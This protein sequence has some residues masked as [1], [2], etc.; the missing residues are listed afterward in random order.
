M[1]IRTMHRRGLK[2]FG[3]QSAK[4]R[5]RKRIS[6]RQRGRFGAIPVQA[7]VVPGF[8][9]T[10]GFFG[11][12][13]RGGELKFL[14]QDIDDAA[15]A[16]GGTVFLNG[17][18]EASLL[19]IPEGNGESERI[20]RKVTVRSINWR[21]DITLPELVAQATPPA[22]DTVRVILYLDKQANG[23]AAATTDILETN[24][25]QSFNN[26]ANSKRFRT[27]MDRTYAINWD[28][29][30]G[31]TASSDYQ[32]KRISDTFFKKVNIPIEYDNTATTGALATI[33]SNNINMLILGITGQA[34]FGSKMRLRYSD[35]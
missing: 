13:G 35:I 18:T 27:L 14:D 31:I 4:S 3:R 8:T 22:G 29:G 32:S 12:F 23:A 30:I 25:Y 15:I 6:I 26:L 19:R 33:R 17:S 2:H 20:G 16:T 34:Q 21:F 11:R 28:V 1:D 24:D 9:R 7:V 5:F 10:G